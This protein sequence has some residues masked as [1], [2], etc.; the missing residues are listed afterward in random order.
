MRSAQGSSTRGFVAGSDYW[1]KL[2]E[3]FG[4]HHG[5]K[6]RRTGRWPVRFWLFARMI[7]CAGVRRSSRLFSEFLATRT[8]AVRCGAVAALCR[9][10]VNLDPPLAKRI[11]ST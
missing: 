4:V 10:T 2:V 6:D 1:A 5:L 7:R 3:H 8:S 9:C 11:G